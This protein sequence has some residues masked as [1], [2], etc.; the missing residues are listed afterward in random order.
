MYRAKFK[1]NCEPG[2][3]CTVF[4]LGVLSVVL[5]FIGSFLVFYHWAVSKGKHH[6]SR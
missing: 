4:G 6:C 3:I 1:Y 2:S 5:F